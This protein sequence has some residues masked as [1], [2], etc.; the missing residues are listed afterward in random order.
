MAE[1]ILRSC[2]LGRLAAASAGER[3]GRPVD[4][5]ALRCLT[6]HGIDVDGLH[7]KPWGRFFGQ[8]RPPVRILIAFANVYAVWA[9]WP[10]ETLISRWYITDPTHSPTAFEKTFHFL[11]ARMQMLLA[12]PL[13]Q[14]DDRALTDEIARMG[15]AS[16]EL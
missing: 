13:A 14:L 3:V 8:G 10:P 7:S 4:P 12:L 15:P 6:S 5:G 16:P 1:A 9:A 2:A 11:Y